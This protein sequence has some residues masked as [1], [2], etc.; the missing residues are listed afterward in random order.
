MQRHGYCTI[1]V[2]PQVSTR[3]I[4]FS[5][6]HPSQSQ[7]YNRGFCAHLKTIYGSM[8]RKRAS[9]R[10]YNYPMPHDCFNWQTHNNCCLLMIE[11]VRMK[12]FTKAKFWTFSNNFIHVNLFFLTSVAAFIIQ[13]SALICLIFTHTCHHH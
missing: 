2:K 11:Q 6:C 3:T 5:K 7:S 1:L 4:S 9:K 10:K 13:V 12:T 8:Y